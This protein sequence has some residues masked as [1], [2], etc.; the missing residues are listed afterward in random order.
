MDHLVICFCHC[1]KTSMCHAIFFSLFLTEKKNSSFQQRMLIFREKPTTNTESFFAQ[2]TYFSSFVFCL[3]L[4]CGFSGKT[5][6]VTRVFYI[7]TTWSRKIYNLFWLWF[8]PTNKCLQFWTEKYLVGL[9]SCF[10]C[11]YD[12]FITTG[13]CG[14]RC[15]Y[16]KFLLNG[17]EMSMNIVKGYDY[18]PSTV[19]YCIKMSFCSTLNP[20]L[21]YLP[22]SAIVMPFY[23]LVHKV[24]F[25]AGTGQK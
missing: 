25:K 5:N 23:F 2:S 3:Q 4:K 24:K 18:L 19:Y 10:K 14:C 1:L 13:F 12:F 8:P 20:C 7:F 9:L 16:I 22:L 11:H 6:F 17:L 21:Y 15:M